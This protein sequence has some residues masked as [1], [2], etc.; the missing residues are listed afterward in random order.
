MRE[1]V[2]KHWKKIVSMLVVVAMLVGLMPSGMQFVEAATDTKSLGTFSYDVSRFHEDKYFLI[3]LGISGAFDNATGDVTGLKISVDDGT[4]KNTYSLDSMK[5][6]SWLYSQKYFYIMLKEDMIPIK[7]EMDSSKM[8]TVTVHAGDVRLTTDSDTIYTID[9]DFHWICNS[10]GYQGI[11]EEF[12]LQGLGTATYQGGYSRWLVY[13]DGLS[14]MSITDVGYTG[15]R[16]KVLDGDTESEAST[17]SLSRSDANTFLLIINDSANKIPNPSSMT[18]SYCDLVVE[19]CTVW[20]KHP[21]LS[22]WYSYRINES[23]TL[24]FYKDG[25]V[26]IYQTLTVN[27]TDESG[28]QPSD[29][30][31]LIRLGVEEQLYGTSGNATSWTG[32]TGTVSDGTN[33]A[34]CSFAGLF[35]G[36]LGTKDNLY[37]YVNNNAVLKNTSDMD[38]DSIYT[39]TIPAGTITQSTYKVKMELK[40]PV[41]VILSPSGVHGVKT[42][43]HTSCSLEEDSTGTWGF[44]YNTETNDGMA[45]NASNWDAEV[46]YTVNGGIYIDGAKK[47]GVKFKKIGATQYAVA[48]DAASV[49]ATEGT[50]VQMKNCMIYGD[51]KVVAFPDATFMYSN[52]AWSVYEEPVVNENTVTLTYLRGSANDDYTRFNI[53]FDYSE[54]FE[55]I[56]QYWNN[57]SI[58]VNGV[59]VSHSDIHYQPYGEEFLFLLPYDA[60]KSGATSYSDLTDQ[61]YIV[62]IRKGT[63]LGGTKWEVAKT[64]TL[65]IYGANIILCEV[66]EEISYD[67]WDANGDNFLNAKDVVYVKANTTN[68]KKLIKTYEMIL[69]GEIKNAGTEEAEYVRGAV[70]VYLD[71]IEISRAAYQ[72]PRAGGGTNYTYVPPTGDTLKYDAPGVDA[73]W[74]GELT[75]ETV[76]NSFINAYE[77]QQYKNAG[78]TTLVPEG[79]CPWSKHDIFG[80]GGGMYANLKYY[81]LLAQDAGLDVFVTSTAADAFIKDMNNAEYGVA[82]KADG[83]DVTITKE[84]IIEDLTALVS[85]MNGNNA[86]S[87]W[88]MQN[89]LSSYPEEYHERMNANIVFDNF[90]G[91]QLSDEVDYT[92]AAK[93]NYVAEQMLKLKSDC[94]FFSSNLTTGNRTDDSS[95]NKTLLEVMNAMGSVT[96][97]FTYDKYPFVQ[98]TIL[99]SDSRTLSK[100]EKYLQK[101]WFTKLKES[102]QGAKGTG[103]ETGITIQAYGMERVLQSNAAAIRTVP[104]SEQ[105]MAWQ[106][107]TG[108][109]YGMKEINYFCYWEHKTQAFFGER[110]TGSMVRYPDAGEEA[111]KSVTTDLYDYVQ[112]VNAEINRFDHVFMDFD[113]QASQVLGGNSSFDYIADSNAVSNNVAFTSTGNG[114]ALVSAMKDAGKSSIA[115][116]SGETEDVEGYWLVNASD[117]TLSSDDSVTVTATFTTATHVVTWIDGKQKMIEL[118]S[119]KKYQA[120]LGEGEGQFIIPITIEE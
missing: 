20:G 109:A 73:V 119:S 79:D 46:Y 35:T 118:D 40:E 95:A 44:K 88:G 6:Y 107:Y 42:H 64:I 30:R 106:V 104:T 9:Q 61:D 108:L 93:Y 29:N 115:T 113:W 80:L 110:F 47:T 83:T 54:G 120:T 97:Q 92:C 21:S 8:Y 59:E 4:T 23:F 45:Y 86:M 102:A 1:T 14:S 100:G 91:I 3:C 111:G 101:D 58:Y 36:D 67:N 43:T 10:S 50:K 26:Y 13:M 99:S 57:N 90:V 38:A 105:Q 18:N 72:G 82:S 19:P 117:P 60:L 94:R 33:S 84:L 22:K 62:E 56:D 24:R 69:E 16:A 7:A 63:S 112:S 39:L 11:P 48:I 87:N 32:M 5:G 70:P 103:I 53:Y 96:K 68:R 17:Y 52:S 81:M 114:S 51:G 31:W 2:A 27:Q 116:V 89:S 74:Y 65:K 49:T 28:N 66:E 98:E 25:S 15:L 37:L 75:S 85:F 41:E 77:M 71:D 12:D 55:F 76:S 78:L 34:E